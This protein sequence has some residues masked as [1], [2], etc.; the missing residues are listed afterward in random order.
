MIKSLEL[1]I[2]VSVSCP[3]VF[4]TDLGVRLGAGSRRWWNRRPST[5]RMHGSE[6]RNTGV[7]STRSSCHNLIR[8]SSLSES[9]H[10]LDYI[11]Y[12]QHS[13]PYFSFHN[14]PDRLLAIVQGKTVYK[15]SEMLCSSLLKNILWKHANLIGNCRFMFKHK[16]VYSSDEPTVWNNA[17]ISF[18]LE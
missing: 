10:L 14:L 9:L 8:F 12:G 11:G 6:S 5:F 4:L 16:R 18:S 3:V 7:L 15:Q 1:R 13:F 17:N 2:Y